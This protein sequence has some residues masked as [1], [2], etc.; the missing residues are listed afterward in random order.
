MKKHLV[1][2]GLL[3]VSGVFVYFQSLP[4]PSFAARTSTDKA[5]TTYN[6]YVIQDTIPRSDTSKHKMK[7]KHKMKK[8]STWRKDS[9]PH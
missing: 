7:M 2:L 8:D 3:I 1:T 4:A 9:V 6:D 5:Y